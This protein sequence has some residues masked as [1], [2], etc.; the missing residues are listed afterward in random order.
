M[1]RRSESSVLCLAVAVVATVT[2]LA[3]TGTAQTPGMLLGRVVVEDGGGPVAGAAVTLE[4]VDSDRRLTLV[5]D[6]EGRF[7]HVGVRPGFYT[8]TVERDGFAAVEIRGVEV[9]AGDRVRLWVEATPADEA[10]FTRRIIRYRRP[11]INV[12]D[13]SLTTRVL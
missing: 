2:W 1:R 12:E 10:P 6:S 11:L 13:G 8:V 5:A 9:R 4:R 7:G 3:G